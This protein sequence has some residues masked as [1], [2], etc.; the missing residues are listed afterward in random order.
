MIKICAFCGK[1][2]KT[3]NASKY[4]SDKC[5]STVLKQQK[6]KADKRRRLKNPDR[7]KIRYWKNR[8]KIL[9]NNKAWREAHKQERLEYSR[10]YEATHRQQRRLKSKLYRLNN[11]DLI[12]KRERKQARLRYQLNP[13]PKKLSAKRYYLKFKHII[14]PRRYI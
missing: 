7:D 13:E 6:R 4:C 3:R 10:N 14:N 1:Q 12:I 8:D 5:K 2:F 9:V 11:H